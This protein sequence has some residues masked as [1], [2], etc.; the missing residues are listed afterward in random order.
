MSISD[1][2]KLNFCLREARKAKGFSSAGQA[3]TVVPY[4][5]ETIGRHER[6]E[7]QLSM[8]DVMTYSELYSDPSLLMV[9]CSGCK[10]RAAIMGDDNTMPLGVPI[11]ALRIS[12]R[13]RN[14][15]NIAEELATILD[16]GMI[17]DDEIPNLASILRYL[18]QIEETTR[19]LVYGCMCTGLFEKV[20]KRSPAKENA[21]YQCHSSQ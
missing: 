12:N 13:L 7:T 16:D 9:Y 10:I 19:E 17:T 2:N 4:S 11:S 1:N 14:A 8:D 18:R 3:S 6:G 5:P 15:A 20:K 21:A